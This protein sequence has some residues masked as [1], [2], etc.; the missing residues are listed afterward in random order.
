MKTARTYRPPV[1]AHFLRLTRAELRDIAALADAGQS[2]TDPAVLRAVLAE[3]ARRVA[4][5]AESQWAGDAF[6]A[7][8]EARWARHPDPLAGK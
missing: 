6:R 7:E 8:R 3:V 5:A 4:A 1:E 2:E